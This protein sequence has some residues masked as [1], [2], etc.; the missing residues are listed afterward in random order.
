[1]HPAWVDETTPPIHSLFV[2]L[3]LS[4]MPAVQ[5][6][7]CEV[8]VPERYPALGI[9]FLNV[10]DACDF[11]SWATDRD[12]RAGHLDAIA[13]FLPAIITETRTH[14]AL[15]EGP[16]SAL[17]LTLSTGLTLTIRHIYPPMT[18]GIDLLT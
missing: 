2:N 15:G 10:S 17:T 4:D 6:L 8:D 13:N 5:V 16:I 9:E 7:P 3:A 12:L 1:M 18:L 11:P 14:D